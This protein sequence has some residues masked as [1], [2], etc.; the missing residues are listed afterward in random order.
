MIVLFE[1]LLLLTG[2]SLVPVGIPGGLVLKVSC[3]VFFLVHEVDVTASLIVVHRILI[4]PLHKVFS[5]ARGS[6]LI[7]VDLSSFVQHYV[8]VASFASFHLCPNI[9][10]VRVGFNYSEVLFSALLS[11]LSHVGQI[12]FVSDKVR[13]QLSVTLILYPAPCVV[14]SRHSGTVRNISPDSRTC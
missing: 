1:I 6:W 11:L 3:V 2:Q 10:S 5:I 14:S 13:V 7:A 12:I 8:G 9:L 4:L